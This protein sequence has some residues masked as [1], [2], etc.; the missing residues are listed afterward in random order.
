MNL[1]TDKTQYYLVVVASLA[2]GVTGFLAACRLLDP[3]I[4]VHLI[5]IS[6][7][8]SV[9]ACGV[10][11]GMSRRSNRHLPQGA[12]AISVL[13]AAGTAMALATAYQLV[14]YLNLPVD[15]LSFSESSYVN[16]IIKLRLGA[17]IYSDPQDNNSYPYTPGSPILTYVVS[18]ALGQ[19]TS[20]P[21][22]RLV[23][24]SYVVIAS[25]AATSVCD[26]LAQRVLSADEYRHRSIWRWVWFALTFLLVTD[27]RF[28]HYTQSLH[29]DGLALLFS[30]FCYW[31]I[32]KHSLKP[33]PWQVWAMALLPGIGFMAKQNVLTWIGVFLVYLVATEAVS[34]RQLALFVL[35]S[36]LVT[37]TVIGVCILLWGENFRYWIFT[38]L[39][40]KQISLPRSILHL[41]Q[42]G[43]YAVL[44]LFSGRVLALQDSSRAITTLWV[45][46]LLLFTMEA[47]TSGLGYQTNHL[48]PGIVIG[49]CWFLIAVL[50]TWPTA[51]TAGS[52]W[53]YRAQEVLAVCMVVLL[54]GALGFV[55]E[56]RNLVPQDF[57]RY[58]AEI[59]NEFQ[60]FAPE[61]VL[62]DTGSWIYLKQNVLMKDRSAPISLHSAKNQPE[63]N[64]QMLAATIKRIEEK[65]Y[66]KILARQLDTGET[67]YDFQNNGSGVKAAIL[68]NYREARRIREVAGI[69]RWW[70]K[71][72]VSEILVLVPN[73]DPARHHNNSGAI[74]M[75]GSEGR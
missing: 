11:W 18:A 26:L 30:V 17:P 54:C 29:N 58:V 51:K 28:N 67:W 20:I 37:V 63:V 41:F 71:H 12:V 16:D 70:P 45:C 56:P 6:V 27:A 59:E 52:W 34:R 50:K 22:Y 24:F 46:W 33:R 10:G 40:S 69:E 31:L 62:M 43:L 66:D 61:K 36:L 60:G 2:L 47:L 3:S 35:G 73:P 19:A 53:Q 68:N 65:T 9:I 38:A 8:V 25:V 72:L 13:L 32:V 42:A 39:G 55:R 57:F 7:I 5:L 23:Q 4:P 14:G 44:G 48:G 75:A 64:H 15:L 21:F 49:G 74:S 1:S